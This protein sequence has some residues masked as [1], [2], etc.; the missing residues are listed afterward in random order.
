MYYAEDNNIDGRHFITK[1][2]ALTIVQ[3]KCPGMTIEELD[4]VFNNDPYEYY[5]WT[6]DAYC[7]DRFECLE[8]CEDTYTTPNGE[9][10]RVLC[11]Y[12]YDG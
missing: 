10:V 5:I 1:E 9:K 2:E 7:N 11:H 3:K 6:Y 4:E 8:C 12:G